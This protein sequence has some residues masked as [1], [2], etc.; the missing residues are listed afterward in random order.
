MIVIELFRDI[1]V[2]YFQG[3]SGGSAQDTISQCSTRIEEEDVEL[4]I[5]EDDFMNPPL[6]SV[7]INVLYSKGSANKLAF[8]I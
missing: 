6:Q 4:G 7:C 3:E 5:L 8:F 1:R 2:L